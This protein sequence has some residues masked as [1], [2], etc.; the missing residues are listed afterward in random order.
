METRGQNPFVDGAP[1]AE[2]TWHYS[3]S[4]P[5]PP[6]ELATFMESGSSNEFSK[7][8][9][10]RR[11]CVQAS[12]PHVKDLP[13][14]DGTTLGAPVALALFSLHSISTDPTIR[15]GAVVCILRGFA[16]DSRW[17]GQGLGKALFSRLHSYSFQLA[18]V[19]ALSEYKAGYRQE[20]VA[21]FDFRLHSG[22]C[23]R[24]PRALMVYQR[25]GA[26]ISLG[27]R[28]M[29]IA[30]LRDWAVRGGDNPLLSSDPS[31]DAAKPFPSMPRQQVAHAPM[32]GDVHFPSI[33]LFS[34]YLMPTA[35]PGKDTQLAFQTIKEAGAVDHQVF[36]RR[37]ETEWPLLSLF[38][39]NSDLKL[40]ALTIGGHPPD[41]IHGCF[42]FS[43]PSMPCAMLEQYLRSPENTINM[44]G[45]PALVLA[46]GK[47]GTPELA[48]TGYNGYEA[49]ASPFNA[50][51]QLLRTRVATTIL[52]KKALM[53]LPGCDALLT[54]A[55]SELSWSVEYLRNPHQIHILCQDMDL[56]GGFGWH[57]DGE[58]TRI[59]KR[60]EHNVVTLALQLSCSAVSAMWVHGFKPVVYEGRGSCVLFHGG[61]LHRTLPW[62]SHV[63][64]ANP[65]FN[66]IK[67]VFLYSD[68]PC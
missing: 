53:S 10:N 33:D 45:H 21:A 60:R 31:G 41:P 24:S 54:M 12:A 48:I 3:N 11:Y 36:H 26:S 32:R 49:T 25:N 5:L 40:G 58:G 4:S 20:Q 23:F 35:F 46:R 27:E 68:V 19:L 37:K 18:Q 62:S 57:T 7:Q 63:L 50:D 17:Q 42:T 56:Q 38:W 43:I 61:C 59:R 15:R 29:T 8:P 9:V 51:S 44:N 13:G 2:L 14:A 22:C 65:H 55:A 1:F 64:D 52:Q 30:Q 34:P 66:I 28:V 16:V 6:D 67:I 47:T 39:Y